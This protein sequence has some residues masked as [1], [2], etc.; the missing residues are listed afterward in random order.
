MAPPS[1]DRRSRR[2]SRRQIRQYGGKRALDVVVAS[3]LLIVLSPVMLAAF[4]AV[5]A[6][7][8]GGALLRQTRVGALGQP[9]VLLKFRT[10]SKDCSAESHQQFVRQMMAGDM[11]QPPDGVYKLSQDPRVTTVG[12]FLRRTSIDELPQLVNVLRGDMSLGRSASGA[13]VGG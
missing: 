11:V 12:R 8:P 7:S 5:R 10:M 3:I 2:A 4:V 9:F 6:T 1:R 13:A